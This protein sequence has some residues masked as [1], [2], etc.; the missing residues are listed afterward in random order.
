MVKKLE[1]FSYTSAVLT[2]IYFQITSKSYVTN[3]GRLGYGSSEGKGLGS[4][5]QS[6]TLQIVE[7]SRS[8]DEKKVELVQKIFE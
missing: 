8:T 3:G 1:F 5:G 6:C 7:N 2:L 4:K